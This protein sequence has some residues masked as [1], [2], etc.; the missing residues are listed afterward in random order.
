MADDKYPGS[1]YFGNSA[2]N[3]PEDECNVMNC[4]DSLPGI[5][6]FTFLENTTFV[7]DLMPEQYG[8][9]TS[10]EPGDVEMAVDDDEIEKLRS[11]VIGEVMKDIDLACRILTIHPHPSHWTIDQVE[12]WLLW[13]LRE[14]KFTESDLNMDYFRMN[15]INLCMMTR[16]DFVN[17]SPRCGDIIH[18]QRDIWI[19]AG[20]MKMGHL[21]SSRNLPI[22]NKESEHYME[23][24]NS[25]GTLPTSGSESASDDESV[26]SPSRFDT[27][28]TPN[29]TS[30]IH[31]W[32]FLK[33]LLRQPE[34]FG[35]CIRYLDREKGIFRIDDSV[36]VAK[37]WGQRKNRPNMNYD[38]LSRSIRQYYKKGIMKKTEKSQRLVYQFV[39]P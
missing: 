14:Y 12:R 31:L 11:L 7:Q 4:E 33:E 21:Y 19:T 30:S 37:L 25:L 2:P 6:T 29:H 18:A 5:G 28:M 38:K 26:H 17:R 8:D 23:R 36:E 34:R 24:T 9:V 1:P 22:Y 10:S 32:Q 39:N 35:H 27:S 16:D 3:S 13:T 15:G 20:K